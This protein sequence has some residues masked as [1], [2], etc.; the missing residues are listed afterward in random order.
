MVAST[1]E[2]PSTKKNFSSLAELR[3]EL[4]KQ[5]Q[6]KERLGKLQETIDEALKDGDKQAAIEFTEKQWKDLI[7]KENLPPLE[8]VQKLL[9]EKIETAKSFT[10]ETKEK[11]GGIMAELRG[12]ATGF[13]EG[14]KKKI[15]EMKEKAEGLKKYTKPA[16]FFMGI[17]LSIKIWGFKIANWFSG[18]FGKKGEYDEQIRLVE[19]EKEFL[20]DPEAA[21]KKYGEEAMKKVKEKAEEGKENIKKSAEKSSILEKLW[22][23]A[24]WVGL[25]GLVKKMLPGKTQ[26]SFDSNSG[27]NILKNVSKFRAFKLLWGAGIGLFGLSAAYNYYTEHPEILEKIWPRPDGEEEQKA[28][29][30]K[31]FTA[32]GVAYESVSGYIG[33]WIDALDGQAL[34]EKYEREWAASWMEF[35]Q[36]SIL[37]RE[38]MRMMK[39]LYTRVE[40]AMTKNPKEFII[41]LAGMGIAFGGWIAF[42]GLK[43]AEIVQKIIQKLYGSAKQHP[44][45]WAL[46]LSIWASGTMNG[47]EALKHIQVKKDMTEADLEEMISG[48]GE[49]Q[50]GEKITEF[51][52]VNMPESVASIASVIGTKGEM[53]LAHTQDLVTNFTSKCDHGLREF[54]EVDQNEKISSAAVSGLEAMMFTI[55]EQKLQKFWGNDSS[56]EHKNLFW[57]NFSWGKIS[58]M[59]TKSKNKEPLTEGDIHELI[60]ASHNTNIRIFPA[61]GDKESAETIQWAIIEEN[62]EVGLPKNLCINPV[63]SRDKQENIAE[64]FSVET[65]VEWSKITNKTYNT[66]RYDLISELG[67]AIFNKSGETRW[68]AEKVLDAGVTLAMFWGKLIAQYGSAIVTLGQGDTLIDIFSGNKEINGQEMLVNYAGSLVPVLIVTSI[69]NKAFS[70][71]EWFWKF[72]GKTALETVT[73]PLKSVRVGQYIYRKWNNKDLAGILKD[74]AVMVRDGIAGLAKRITAF[75]MERATLNILKIPGEN[76]RTKWELQTW[77]SML[78][79]IKIQ[80]EIGKTANQLHDKYKALQDFFLKHHDLQEALGKSAADFPN[81]NHANFDVLVREA[82]NGLR[83]FDDEIK[84]WLPKVTESIVKVYEKQLTSSHPD[85]ATRRIHAAGEQKAK[86]K[87][88]SDLEWEKKTLEWKLATA[89]KNLKKNTND[90]NLRDAVIDATHELATFNHDFWE[91]HMNIRAEIAALNNAQ[92][93]HVHWPDIRRPGAQAK[94][95]WKWVLWIAGIF[96]AG[97][98]INKAAVAIHGESSEEDYVWEDIDFYGYGDGADSH[99]EIG[100]TEKTIEKNNGNDEW[101]FEKSETFN[102]FKQ[103][104]EVI[105]NEYREELWDFMN[106][107]WIQKTSPEDVKNIIQKL[108]A[109]HLKKVWDIKKLIGTNKDMAEKFWGEKFINEKSWEEV[110]P[111]ELREMKV[112]AFMYITKKNNILTLESMNQAEF[113][114]S[115]F[116]L[117]KGTHES[118]LEQTIWKTGTTVLKGGVSLIPYVWNM[119]SWYDAYESFSEGNIRDGLW[120]VGWCVGGLALDIVSFWSAWTALRATKLGAKIATNMVGH[121][122]IMLW[123]QTVQALSEVPR[124]DSIKIDNL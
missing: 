24:L 80:H 45:L 109:S 33:K 111:Q 52:G 89:E 1:L 46:G 107:E 69:K 108:S 26:E 84:R 4:T 55:K 36:D 19:M 124:S 119:V 96:G 7:S 62:G 93:I 116:L 16:L 99:K 91:R 86:E 104:I 76:L 70:A 8:I 78:H 51:T 81:I 54:F 43:A 39:L 65:V 103:K 20:R 121:T 59:I 23:G 61:G 10:S 53:L 97:Y 95:L 48:I 44:I 73:Y 67:K 60:E 37:F 102:E 21:T 122:A 63:Q 115:L 13:T 30:E 11:T 57:E 77:N 58:E 6:N 15:E 14:A 18:L 98:L 9:K 120:N 106:P 87:A 83:N 68:I 105:E 110:I 50:V 28:W 117:Y 27:D 112:T 74:P 101:F 75:P 22:F 5:A 32:A 41:V 90:R 56:E 113:E 17:G 64:E 123:A 2:K 25:F 47:W 88:L 94:F 40:L 92:Q 66:F 38:P 3:A 34:R 79:D 12:K 82:S 29:Y 42:G 72:W 35:L 114:R 85:K 31:L 100:K 71:S 49:L 118:W